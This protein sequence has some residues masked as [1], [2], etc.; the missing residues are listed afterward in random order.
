MF[1]IHNNMCCVKE[2]ITNQQ[3]TLY[4]VRTPY[5]LYDEYVKVA[6]ESQCAGSFQIEMTPPVN[7]EIDI[8]VF[9]L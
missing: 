7:I 2:K 3:K 1:E 5:H 4:H 8:D 6:L 9:T